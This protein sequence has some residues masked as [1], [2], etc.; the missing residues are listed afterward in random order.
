MQNLQVCALNL[1]EAPPP[2]KGERELISKENIIKQSMLSN[3][4]R[5]ISIYSLP[6][7]N[8]H[9]IFFFKFAP[10]GKNSRKVEST[11]VEYYVRRGVPVIVSSCL[12]FPT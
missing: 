12:S 7:A 3:L 6:D 10:P 1:T 2:Q 5:F 11:Y 8:F 4:I 9:T